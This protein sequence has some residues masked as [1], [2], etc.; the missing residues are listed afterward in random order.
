[1][2]YIV[3]N[4]YQIVDVYEI[5]LC[6]AY[7]HHLQQTSGMKQKEATEAKE[8]ALRRTC[9]FSSYSPFSSNYLANID[10]LP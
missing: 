1:M 10:N 2:T 3:N 4:L 8:L 6:A 9:H 7:R 5:V